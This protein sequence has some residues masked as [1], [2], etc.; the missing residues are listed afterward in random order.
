MRRLAIIVLVPLVALA[1]ALLIAQC[2]QEVTGAR[3]AHG[4]RASAPS[5]RSRGY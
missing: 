3:V 5:A 1:I 4:P 2:H